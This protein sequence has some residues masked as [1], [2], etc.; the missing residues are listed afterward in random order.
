MTANLPTTVSLTGGEARHDGPAPAAT[1]LAQG[2][3]EN[4]WILS[5]V[6]VRVIHTAALTDDSGLTIAVSSEAGK[7]RLDFTSEHQFLAGGLSRQAWH[8]E[9]TGELPVEVLAAV[10]S[11]NTAASD[12][13]IFVGD[14][15]IAAGWKECETEWTSPDKTGLVFHLNP[16]EGADLPWQIQ[17]TSGRPVTIRMSEDTPSSVI[18]AFALTDATRR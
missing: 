2:M 11:A 3:L 5:G 13:D 10:S 14:L 16:D 9:A 4:G 1:D 17:H 8:A 6:A 15:L 18:A 7:I 12:D